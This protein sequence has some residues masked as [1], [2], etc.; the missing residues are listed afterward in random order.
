MSEADARA[1][2]AAVE[3]VGKSICEASGGGWDDMTNEER[4]SFD[5]ISQ[6]AIVAHLAFLNAAGFRLVPPGMTIRPQ[7]EQEAH[8]MAKQVRAYLAQ[9]IH[10]KQRRSGLMGSPKLILPYDA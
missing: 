10:A 7:T 5:A 6:A 2:K 1:E 8:E 9:P 4:A 3:V